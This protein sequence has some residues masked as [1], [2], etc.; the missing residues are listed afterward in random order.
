[1]EDFKTRDIQLAVYLRVKGIDAIRIELVNREKGE[2]KW[3]YKRTEA[4]TEALSFWL[5]QGD[6]VLVIKKSVWAYRHIRRDCWDQ[7][8]AT[9]PARTEL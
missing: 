5:E 9:S 3:T 1:M 6:D 8:K 7:S 2:A 4:L